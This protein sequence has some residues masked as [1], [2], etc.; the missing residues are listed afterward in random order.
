MWFVI[1]LTL[2][3]AA[4]GMWL[5]LGMMRDFDREQGRGGR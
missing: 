2:A 5:T 3:N 4:V 1:L